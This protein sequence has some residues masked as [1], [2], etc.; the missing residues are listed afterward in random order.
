LK[1]SEGVGVTRL[2]ADGIGKGEKGAVQ[3]GVEC[4]NFFHPS[5]IRT[6]NNSILYEYRETCI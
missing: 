2:E 6:I 5:T 1:N 4:V 3:H